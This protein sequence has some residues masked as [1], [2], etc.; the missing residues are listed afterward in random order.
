MPFSWP[1]REHLRDLTRLMDNYFCCEKPHINH[2]GFY[3]S[4][5]PCW[6]N[7]GFH[8]ALGTSTYCHKKSFIFPLESS[9]DRSL[10]ADSTK[11]EIKWWLKQSEAAGSITGSWY[12]DEI[13]NCLKTW[14]NFFF[15]LKGKHLH[16]HHP[17]VFAGNE[18]LHPADTHI[19]QRKPRAPASSIRAL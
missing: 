17:C 19:V 13:K 11:W 7:A 1:F 12:K 9:A 3:C 10:I 2:S 16:T 8:S 14:W 18:R 15:L 5:K 6:N 4:E